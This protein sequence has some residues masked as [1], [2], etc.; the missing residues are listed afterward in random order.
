MTMKRVRG[1]N[2]KEVGAHFNG[3]DMEKFEQT[4]IYG[5]LT[6]AIDN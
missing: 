5:Y 1:E 2:E 3:K 6:R 4:K